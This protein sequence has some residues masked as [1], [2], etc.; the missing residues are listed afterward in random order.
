MA[1]EDVGRLRQDRFLEVR[2]VGDRAFER[3]DAA[4]GRVE[5]LEQLAGDARRDL[6]AEAARQLILVRDDD[7]V[8]ALDVR[9]DRVPVVRHDRPQVEHRDADAD[10]S[11]PAA[12][13]AAIA[14]PAR[15]R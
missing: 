8:G 7:A 11:R 13:R 2:A 10:P 1:F 3:A 14:A 5:V 9:G 6:G 12:P 15:P 4:D